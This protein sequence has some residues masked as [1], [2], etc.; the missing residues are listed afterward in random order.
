MNE[1][2]VKMLRNVASRL[3]GLCMAIIVLCV[4]DGLTS[5]L[6]QEF[7]NFALLPGESMLVNGHMPP[8]TAEIKDLII[9]GS[10]E[11]IRFHPESTYKGFWMGG[12]MWK[13]EATAAENAA[14]GTYTVTVRGG[15]EE[16]T[17]SSMV[18]TFRVYPDAPSL[19]A[20]A[21]ALVV[22]YVGFHPYAVAA[23]LL[24]L[25]ILCG[26]TV[27]FL[28][29]KMERDMA[30]RGKAEIYMIK[31][32]PEGLQI[33]FG[34][35]RDHGVEPGALVC[36]HNEAG[37]VVGRAKVTGST[38]TDST[39]VLAGDGL[40]ELGNLVTQDSAAPRADAAGK[41]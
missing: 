8:D 28:A 21:A 40:A 3:G 2:T 39:A 37:L 24:P 31:R 19:R 41:D 23:G 25:A 32:S 20:N 35:G 30:A 33:S 10:L 14:A 29:K 38:E 18:F 17:H 13:G 11:T 16:K 7:N 5:Q 26:L 6:R 4:I 27:F 1:K 36:I 34:L 9:E 22:R 15:K 12:F